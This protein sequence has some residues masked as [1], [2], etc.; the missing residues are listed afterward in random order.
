MKLGPLQPDYPGEI[1]GSCLL[2]HVGVGPGKV[3]EAEPTNWQSLGWSETLKTAENIRKQ[4]FQH[5]TVIFPTA[6]GWLKLQH[7]SLGLEKHVGILSSKRGGNIG[8]TFG[9]AKVSTSDSS[10][11]PPSYCFRPSSAGSGVLGLGFSAAWANYLWTA[12]ACG[13]LSRETGKWSFDRSWG[14]SSMIKQGLSGGHE[15]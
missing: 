3:G 11:G 1:F 15:L 6:L 5:G 14:N 9:K 2:S 8:F 7:L 13:D 4:G 10:F 12:G